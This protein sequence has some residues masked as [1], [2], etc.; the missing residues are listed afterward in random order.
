MKAFRRDSFPVALACLLVVA[1][2]VAPAAAQEKTAAIDALLDGY[3][4]RGQ[5]NGSVLVAETAG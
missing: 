3:H 1:A 2:G 4:L 5:F